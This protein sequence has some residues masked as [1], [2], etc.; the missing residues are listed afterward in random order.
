MTPTLFCRA[1]PAASALL[2]MLIL[3]SPAPATASVKPATPQA[4]ALATLIAMEQR[5]AP[6]IQ[7]LV[8]NNARWCSVTMPT[9]GWL[10]GDRR[11]YRESIWPRARTAYQA[12]DADAPFVA[13]L[14][15]AGPAARAGLQA[16][17]AISR[18]NGV[19]VTAADSDP[20]ARMASA[21]TLLAAL[22]GDAPFSV[23]TQNGAIITVHPARGCAS[24]FRVEATNA[25]QAKADGLLVLVSAGM[26]RFADDDDELATVIAHE[27]AH[28]ILRHR[29]RL[30]AAAITRGLAQFF[31]RNARLTKITE[32]EADRLSVWLLV[33]AGYDPAAAGRFWTNYGKRHGG[34]IFQS[35]THPTWR[36]RVALV[37]AEAALIRRARAT[38][39][40]AAPPMIANPATLD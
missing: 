31:G 8:T 13:A 14:D 34:G 39:P 19:T 17:D 20:H 29:A 6:I 16:G 18:I 9:P 11:L 32:E 33:G 23:T 15:P 37:T 22:P 35:P 5:V 30:D 24:E 7:R 4:D 2:A 28:N 36:R 10:L 25:V 38:D 27:L 26:V 12:S 1:R 21:H 3:V 40:F